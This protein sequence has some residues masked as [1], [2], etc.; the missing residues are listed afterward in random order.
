[1]ERFSLTRAL[2]DAIAGRSLSAALSS[3]DAIVRFEDD[4]PHV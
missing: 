3:L 2:A 1:L 4:Q